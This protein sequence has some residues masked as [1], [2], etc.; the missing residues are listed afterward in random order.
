MGFLLDIRVLPPHLHQ[1][2]PEERDRFGLP[3]HWSFLAE[4]E[5]QFDARVA[6][7]NILARD[8]VEAVM[9]QVGRKEAK[10]LFAAA[11]RA[12]RKGKQRDAKWNEALVA[13][14]DQSIAHGVPS[15][16][17]A[18]DAAERMAD[19]KDDCPESCAR[20]IRQLVKERAYRAAADAAL[21]RQLLPTFLAS[22]LEDF[23]GS[24]LEGPSMDV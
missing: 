11:L 12:P 17:A 6:A 7:T 19:G 24:E 21:H 20:H 18:R 1:P 15:T 14:Y 10:R 8:G 9:R 4:D 16:R 13:A 22:E 2:P 3:M 23:L 5:R